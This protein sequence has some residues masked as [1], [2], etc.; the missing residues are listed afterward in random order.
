MEPNRKNLY[1]IGAGG[2]GRELE[3]WLSLIPEELRDFT[4]FGYIDDNLKAL[5]GFKSKYKILGTIAGFDFNKTDYAVISIAEPEIKEKVYNSLA[6]RVRIYTFIAHTAIIGDRNNIGTGS[7]ICPNA[8]VSVNTI[9]GKCVT[10]NCG[11]QLG[12]DSKIG[13]FT[14][15]MANV[16]IGGAS[17]IAGKVYF[18]SQSTLVPGKRICDNAKIS[19]GSVVIRNISKPGVY[20][21][22]PAS[23]FF[24]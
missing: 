12:H 4:I 19:A 6:D 5:D 11:T 8:I 2:L 14:S 13:D 20:F 10:V 16:M 3:L 1:I 21:G 24:T 9:I 23:L 7:V 18:G 15:F 22:N 17:S